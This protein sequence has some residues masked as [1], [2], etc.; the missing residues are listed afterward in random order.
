M[1]DFNLT[2][3]GEIM[4]STSYLAHS[5]HFYDQHGT[6]TGVFDF[7]KSPVSFRGDADAAAKTFTEGVI[8]Q[9]GVYLNKRPT[10]EPLKDA[11]CPLL[12]NPSDATADW[13]E[14]YLSY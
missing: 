1:T 12:K 5:L 10:P 7:S 4:I 6:E 3:P 2:Q 11:T 13:P 14:D 8:Q 9:F